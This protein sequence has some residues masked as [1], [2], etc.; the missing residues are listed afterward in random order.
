MAPQIKKLLWLVAI[1]ILIIGAGT[2][3]Y[4][5]FLTHPPGTGPVQISMSE[6]KISTDTNEIWIIGLG[7]SVTAGFGASAGKSYWDLLVNNAQEEDLSLGGK[8]L[9][10]IYPN[11]ISTNLSKSGSTSLQHERQ[12]IPRLPRDAQR[13][14]IIVI[15]TGGNDLIHSYGKEPPKEGAMY[16][17]TLDQAKPWIQ[18]FGVRLDKMVREINTHFPKGAEIY[19]AT[20]YDPSDGTGVMRHTGLPEWLDGVKILAEYNKLILNLNKNHPN[21]RVVEMHQAFLGHG[22]HARHWWEPYYDPADPFC[23]LAS[24]IEDPNDRGYDAIQ[25]LMWNAIATR[26]VRSP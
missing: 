14:A 8:C 1:M 17:A 25:R 13:K 19:M 3:Y 24:N 5:L 6:A 20:I 10:R 18:N 21:V 9:K 11:L 16:G 15:T 4:S 23:W 7:D 2:Y 12:Q 22:L 26:I